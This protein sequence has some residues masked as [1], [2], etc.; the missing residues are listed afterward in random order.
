L[1]ATIEQ[2]AS[3]RFLEHSTLVLH[4]GVQTLDVFVVLLYT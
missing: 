2:V 1:W 3:S 4:G